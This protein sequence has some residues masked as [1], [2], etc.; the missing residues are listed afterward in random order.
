MTEILRSVARSAK[1]AHGARFAPLAGRAILS[2]GLAA[3]ALFA[4][5]NA[6]HAQYISPASRKPFAVTIGTF[7]PTDA[8]VRRAGGTHNLAVGIDWT[9]Q[10]IPERNAVSVLS[11]GY[12]E[13]DGFKM[14]PATVSF[15]IRENSLDLGK[16]YY[17]GIGGGL[18]LTRVAATDTSGENKWIPGGFVVVG[19]DLT[20]KYF[21]ELKYHYVNKYDGKFVGGAQVSVG[22]RF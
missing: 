10:Q 12:I 1:A 18:Y 3:L 6:A 13:R 11:L 4:V 14:I 22:L 17:Y 7:I 8:D 2:A 19:V 16:G 20:E 9:A 21:G 5:S 15:I